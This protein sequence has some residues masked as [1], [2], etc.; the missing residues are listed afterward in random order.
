[1]NKQKKNQ[2]NVACRIGKHFGISSQA[3]S[4]WMSQGGFLLGEYPS[5][6]SL[7]GLS[8]RMK[9]IRVHIPIQPTDYLSQEA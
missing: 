6:K 9:S 3:V 1:M 8:H 5:F 4:K 7:T 2:H